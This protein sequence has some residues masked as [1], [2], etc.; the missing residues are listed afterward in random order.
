MGNMG[1]PEL[2]RDEPIILESRNVKFKSI[3]F[4]AKLTSKRIHLTDSKKNV[5]PSQDISLSIIR[6]VETGENAIR[7]H[8]LILSLVSEAGEKHQVVLTFAR[9][10]GVERKRE[11]NEWAKKL[12]SL[13]PPSV[14]VITPSYVSEIDKES[15]TKREVPTPAQGT[16]TTTGPAKKKIEIT[17][18]RGTVIEKIPVTPPSEEPPAPPSGSF[19]TR[20]GNRVPLKSTF[21]NNCGTPITQPSVLSPGPKPPVPEVKV[22]VPPRQPLPV[23][24]RERKKVQPPAPQPVVT[25]VQETVLTPAPQPIVTK[26]RET[27]LTP[28][29]QPVVAKVQETV[30][31]PTPQPVVT[32]VQETV[33]TPAPQ[34][35]VAKV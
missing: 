20:C 29:P 4:D 3:S 13:I 22:S 30:L 17:R 18:P 7:D 12:K 27:V 21:C 8:F 9:Q 25:K 23:G 35:V 33:L 15:L 32:K 19:C 31:T 34:P 14:P 26:V 6:S 10:A 1:Y 16:A 11:C 5:I 2:D 24:M 28:T